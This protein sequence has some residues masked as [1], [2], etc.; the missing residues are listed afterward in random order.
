MSWTIAILLVLAGL[1]FSA[2]FSGSET[3]LYCLNRLRIQLGVDRGDRRALRLARFLRDEQAAL[4][5]TLIGTNL[6]NYITAAAAAYLFAEHLKLSDHET[7]ILTVIVLTPIVFVFGEVTP[8]NL[9][10]RNADELMLKGSR[11]L[12]IANRCF[13]L[14][15]AVWVLRRMAGVVTR[16]VGPDAAYR[17]PFD[18]KR[19]VALL[20]REALVGDVVGDEQSELVDRVLALSE[21]HLHGV[22][23]PRNR[24]VTIGAAAG[25][26]ELLALARR[27]R[28][29]YIP[30]SEGNQR[31]VIGAIKI[32]TLVGLDDWNIV[33]D[34]L[35]PVTALTAHDTVAIA[36]A[37]MQH[38]QDPLG[39]VT[40]RGG[41]MLGIVTMKDLLEEVVGELQAW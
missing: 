26:R 36:I 32:D 2:F 14:T 7:Q 11:T 15:G 16:I 4:S 10:Q 29:R 39:I 31:Q 6:M 24:V 23:V 35:R 22:M 37:K 38:S 30:V 17:R 33:S 40:D 27:T 41:Q 28:H 21:T 19:R 18:P 25:R 9:F 1:F 5:V 12:A 20:L 3:G 8:K 13:R 34:R